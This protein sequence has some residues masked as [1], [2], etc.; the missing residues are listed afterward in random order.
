MEITILEQ[1]FEELSSPA[2]K[3]CYD[4]S[5]QTWT[6]RDPVLFSPQKHNQEH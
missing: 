6:H 1:L 4:L 2:I 3:G 5:T